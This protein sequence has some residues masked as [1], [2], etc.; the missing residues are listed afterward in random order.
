MDIIMILCTWNYSFLMFFFNFARY[1]SGQKNTT[2]QLILKKKLTIA[3]LGQSLISQDTS[4]L[5]SNQPLVRKKGKSHQTVLKLAKTSEG[6][7]Y[8]QKN[9]NQHK[10][11]RSSYVAKQYT[12][13]SSI[14]FCEKAVTLTLYSHFHVFKKWHVWCMNNSGL[15]YIKTSCGLWQHL[16]FI[17]S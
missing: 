17:F 15:Q 2:F 13:Q 8:N 9:R 5:L 14:T 4:L 10:K 16:G 7:I 6:W 1:K 11:R 3:I 12:F